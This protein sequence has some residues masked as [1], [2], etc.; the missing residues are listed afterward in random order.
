MSGNWI[1]MRLASLG[2]CLWLVALAVVVTIYLAW[3]VYPIEIGALHIRDS[4]ALSTTSIRENFNQLLS[5][6]TNPVVAILE[7]EDF[8]SSESGLKHFADVK[9]LFMIAQ[10]VF[11][12]LAIPSFY[13]L[14]KEI[15]AARLALYLP[16]W[17]LMALIPLGLALVAFV[18]G[19][20]Q[21]FTLFHQIFF[22]GD[23]SWLFNPLTDPVIYIL[24]ESFFMHCFILFLFCYEL[25]F[26][27]LWLC[28]YRKIHNT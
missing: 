26:L 10:G 14:K 18:I 11:L 17:R 8:P 5:Y 27:S 25:C 7:M 22:L 20:D 21:F 12:A 3:L 24:P 15:T 28:S 23:D 9:A 16:L 6:L 2:F 1:K 13:F 4:V 19:F